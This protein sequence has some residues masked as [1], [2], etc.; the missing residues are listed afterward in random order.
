MPKMTNEQ[1]IKAITNA[2]QRLSMQLKPANC[3]TFTGFELRTTVSTLATPSI[4]VSNLFDSG[5]PILDNLVTVL[6][7]KF[8]KTVILLKLKFLNQCKFQ[9]K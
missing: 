8:S 9:I 1:Y 4:L 3:L 2:F 7:M 6:K 5:Q